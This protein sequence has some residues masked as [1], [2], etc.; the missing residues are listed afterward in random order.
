[1]CL[2]LRSTFG[3]FSGSI[4]TKIRG[5]F[6]KLLTWA[7][8]WFPFNRRSFRYHTN[9]SLFMS[10]FMCRSKVST[11]L[12]IHLTT[13]TFRLSSAHFYIPLHTNFGVPHLIMAH[14]F[15]MLVW[16]YH[17]W[18]SA[19]VWHTPKFLVDP[20]EGPSMR[21]CGRSWNLEHDPT[22]STRGGERGV[23][24]VPGKTRK[25]WQASLTHTSLHKTLMKW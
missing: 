21:Q 18:S 11:W 16:S 14:L 17:W 25:N 12:L 7:R 5:F 8:I 4:L 6:N 3:K 2:F 13:P 22:S 9:T 24:E 15:T 10:L 19:H 20:L 23:L 1:M